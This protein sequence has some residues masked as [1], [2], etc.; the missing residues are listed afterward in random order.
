MSSIRLAHWKVIDSQ[1]STCD[2]FRKNKI[3]I[4]LYDWTSLLL[5]EEQPKEPK[6]NQKEPITESNVKIIKNFAKQL[7][8]WHECKLF[9]C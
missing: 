2:R 5:N 3:Q 7:A 1:C 4:V 9:E 8:H 6:S